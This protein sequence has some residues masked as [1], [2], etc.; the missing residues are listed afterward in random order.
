[1]LPFHIIVATDLDNGI[2]KDGTMPWHL[3]EDLHYFKTLTS[4]PEGGLK[5]TVIMGRK[6][7]FSLPEKFR[8]LPNRR[9]VI[10]S[11]Q[12]PSQFPNDVHVFSSLDSALSASSGSV[13]VMGGGQLYKEAI[14]HPYLHTVYRTLI[15]AHF[16]CDTFFP[17]LGHGFT[18]VNETEKETSVSGVGYQFQSFRWG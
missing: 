13:F 14:K 11:S 7:W 1:M 5:P 2:G 18:L 4:Q 8:P 12:A 9:N 15:H 17:E 6:T 3:P 10:I 16:N